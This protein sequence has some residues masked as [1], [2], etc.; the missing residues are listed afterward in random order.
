MHVART[1][2]CRF[3]YA[4]VMSTFAVFL[5]LGGG[6]AY[7]AGTVLS[8]D[9]VHGKVKAPDIARNAV[10]SPKI[11][12]GAVTLTDIAPHAVDSTKVLGDSLTAGNL[13][14]DSVGG[15]ELLANSVTTSDIADR[16][17]NMD[18]IDGVDSSGSISV[19]AV[20]DSR[21]VTISA[22][23][24]GARPGDVAVLTTNGVIPNGITI[25]AQRALADTVHIKVCNL[26]GATSAAITD[27]PVRII[28]IH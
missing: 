20:S 18:D 10:T 6:T 24:P 17:V 2:F 12:T 15:S 7:A 19:G 28:T 21:C 14:A 16:T 4:N 26:S 11:R 5:V 23:V 8:G 9:M 3:T 27:L 1:S 22:G 13:A 25:S